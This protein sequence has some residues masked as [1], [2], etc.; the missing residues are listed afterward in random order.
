MQQHSDRP[1]ARTFPKNHDFTQL[2]E[3]IP[4]LKFQG[5]KLICPR[6]KKELDCEKGP[7]AHKCERRII[8]LRRIAENH[9]VGDKWVMIG[10]GESVQRMASEVADLHKPSILIIL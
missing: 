6:C 10:S 4:Q 9:Q 1:I 8:G 7:V 2:H 5:F 3:M